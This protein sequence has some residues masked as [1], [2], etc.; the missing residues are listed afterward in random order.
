[1]KFW[2]LLLVAAIGTVAITTLFLYKIPDERKYDRRE[3]K[4]LDEIYE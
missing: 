2:K 3:E 4:E 1:M